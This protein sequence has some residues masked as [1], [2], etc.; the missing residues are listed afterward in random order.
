[1]TADSSG[2]AG[3]VRHSS[4]VG[5]DRLSAQLSQHSYS[6]TGT[7]CTPTP[8]QVHFEY[9]SVEYVSRR[10]TVSLELSACRIT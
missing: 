10:W 8:T 9:V 2:L 7:L 6:N 1:M 3:F 5:T 4:I